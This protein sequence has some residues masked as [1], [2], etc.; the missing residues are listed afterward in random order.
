MKR[1]V[2]KFDADGEVRAI[3][4]SASIYVDTPDHSSTYTAFVSAI[5]ELGAFAR[6][7]QVHKQ[8]QEKANEVP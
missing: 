8:E 3:K 7:K 5:D 4:E 2:V 1:W 6:A